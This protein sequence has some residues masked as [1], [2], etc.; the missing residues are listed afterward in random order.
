MLEYLRF[1]VSVLLMLAGLFFIAMATL[2]V[3][4]Y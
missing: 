3:Y 2:G 4:R 1:G